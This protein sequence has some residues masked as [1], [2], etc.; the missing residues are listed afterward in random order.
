M[1]H[2]EKRGKL[3]L[4][5]RFGVEGRELRLVIGQAGEGDHRFTVTAKSPAA[6]EKELE[7]WSQW[8]LDAGYALVALP[9]GVRLGVVATTESPRGP[10]RIRLDERD[11]VL[12]TGAPFD[13]AAGDRVMVEGVHRGAKRVPDFM[14]GSRLRAKRVL[15]FPKVD[16]KAF[17]LKPIPPAGVRARLAKKAGKPLLGKW[18][19]EDEPEGPVFPKGVKPGDLIFAYEKGVHR[20]LRYAGT[21]RGG[22]LVTSEPVLTSTFERTSFMPSDAME[23]FCKPL[24]AALAREISRL[25]GL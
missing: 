10:G 23:S 2:F 3:G 11:D 15:A 12:F 1:R 5:R 21:K 18:T 25:Y 19:W 24:P 7:R 20:F 17:P 13:V 22:M 8:A 16:W 14:F 9:A 4:F 6:A